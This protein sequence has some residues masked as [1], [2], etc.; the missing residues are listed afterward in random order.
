MA[1]KLSTG[2]VNYIT[3]FGSFRQAMEDFLLKIYGGATAPTTVDEA[4]AGSLLVTLSRASATTYITGVAGVP[5]WGEVNT[6][7]VTSFAVGE[8]WS[9]DITISGETLFTTRTFTNTPDVGDAKDVA[10]KLVKLFQDAGLK[11]CCSGTDGYVYVM[12]P[13]KHSLLI[14]LHA[15]STGTVT[16]G[17]A[18]YA[19]VANNDCLHL[20]P[21]TLGVIGKDSDVWSGVNAATGV[22]SYFRMVRPDDSGILSTT[23]LRLQ[24]GCATSGSEMTMSNTTLTAAAT[25]TLDSFTVT[26]PLVAA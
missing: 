26:L 22:A 21:P 19:A 8:T 4:P 15:G 20:G 11:A 1:V 16:I 24:G 17:D 3:G 2:M 9:F 13:S 12:A 25:C 14:A 7:L 18:V 5:G 6:V 23:D 10:V